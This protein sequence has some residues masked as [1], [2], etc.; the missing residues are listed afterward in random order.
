M[1]NYQFVILWSGFLKFVNIVILPLSWYIEISTRIRQLQ[2][3]DCSIAGSTLYNYWTDLEGFNV[4]LRPSCQ[5]FFCILQN[6]GPRLNC[7]LE[8]FSP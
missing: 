2:I 3:V 5:I 6:S 7:T 1:L 4:D 8:Y